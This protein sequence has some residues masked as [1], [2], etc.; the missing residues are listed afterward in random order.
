MNGYKV[1]EACNGADALRVADQ[2]AGQVH[3]LAS[4][5]VMPIM[6]GQRLAQEL[7]VRRPGVKVLF[8]SGY[9]DDAFT[10][11]SLGPGDA[12]LQKPVDPAVLL[13]R[14]RSLLDDAA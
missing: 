11:G 5:V 12:F 8:M 3:L 9:T 1:L 14:L 2:Y 10:N 6:G 13:L 4:D 7:T